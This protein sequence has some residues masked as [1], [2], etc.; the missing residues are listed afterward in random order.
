MIIPNKTTSATSEPVQNSVMTNIGPNQPKCLPQIPS[1]A[2][3]NI[4]K[5]YQPT[6]TCDNPGPLSASSRQ[7]CANS[8][9]GSTLEGL[10]A[11]PGSPTSPVTH[12]V[13]DRLNLDDDLME[14]L[15]ISALTPCSWDPGL[16]L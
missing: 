8:Q 13:D 5:L 7:V 16:D 14:N 15:E 3:S 6:S 10:C 12:V 1:G 2:F 11:L 9:R 4:T